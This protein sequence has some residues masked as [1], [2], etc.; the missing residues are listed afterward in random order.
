MSGGELTLANLINNGRGA[1][2]EPALP[3]SSINVGVAQFHAQQMAASGSFSFVG[4]DGEDIFRRIVCSGGIANVPTGVI[5]IGYST[6][7]QAVF[8]ALQ[9]D[10]GAFAVMYDFTF[11]TNL[12]VG[13]SG[14]YWVIIIQ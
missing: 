3:P 13:Y 1:A 4:T 12:S 11:A 10:Y 5:A 14:G 2:Q 7:P 6:D 9:N 8:A